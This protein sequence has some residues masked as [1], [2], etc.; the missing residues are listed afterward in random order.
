M[1]SMASQI[2]SLMIV[3]WTVYSRRR[4][5]K[6]SKLCVTGLCEGNLSV[7]YEFPTQRASKAE[8]VDVIMV[9]M[10]LCCVWVCMYVCTQRNLHLSIIS[11][12]FHTLVFQSCLSWFL[13]IAVQVEFTN[14]NQ[15]TSSECSLMGRFDI[16]YLLMGWVGLWGFLWWAPSAKGKDH[17]GVSSGWSSIW[18]PSNTGLSS[19]QYEQ[20]PIILGIWPFWLTPFFFRSIT[21]WRAYG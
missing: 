7:T 19:T 13:T 18:H 14:S 5:K 15:C 20:I 10:S 9:F 12:T 3:C 16:F 4:W 21:F 6:T 2:T 17:H 11:Y 1:G 8:N